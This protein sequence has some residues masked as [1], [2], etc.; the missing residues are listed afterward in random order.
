MEFI[1]CPCFAGHPEGFE[2][3]LRSSS[4]R[5]ELMYKKNELTGYNQNFKRENQVKKILLIATVVACALFTSAYLRNK[6]LPR[7]MTLTSSAFANNQTIPKKY[8]SAP[9]GANISPPL[10]WSNAPAGTKSFAIIC[11]DPDAPHPD[12]PREKPWVHW[13]LFNIPKN[14][15]SIAQNT[16]PISAQHGKND[17]G[18][19]QYGGPLPP[20]GKPHR[21]FF[22][23]Y[24]LNSATITLN[25]NTA[26]TRADFECQFKDQ[27]IDTGQ[28]IGTYQR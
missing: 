26:I 2:T 5:T 23:I 17:W 27:I 11:D 16:P 28:L 9:E 18:K 21:Y 7:N 1:P 15:T 14:V 13:V 6:Q 22:K 12:A 4:G 20:P 19:Q 10:A 8:A 24:A 3:S 25:S